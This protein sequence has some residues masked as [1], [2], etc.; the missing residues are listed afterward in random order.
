MIYKVLSCIIEQAVHGSTEAG[1]FKEHDGGRQGALAVIVSA[2]GRHSLDVLQSSLQT[3]RGVRPVRGVV[4]HVY[5]DHRDRAV[6]FKGAQAGKG[7]LA[8][9]L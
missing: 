2:V 3:G 7:L 8:V 9:M 5:F 1:H 4:P 6:E